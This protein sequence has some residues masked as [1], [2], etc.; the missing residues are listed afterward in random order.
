M[1]D[2]KLTFDKEMCS[3]MYKAEGLK[4][5]GGI[6]EGFPKVIFEQISEK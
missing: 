4:K 5:S 3:E 6:R 2:Y 1:Y